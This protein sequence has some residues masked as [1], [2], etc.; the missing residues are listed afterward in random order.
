MRID[1]QS[2]LAGYAA[3]RIRNL[4]LRHATNLTVSSVSKFMDITQAE[5]YTLLEALVQKGL[6]EVKSTEPNPSWCCT[7]SGVQLA[8][9]SAARPIK[10]AT[11]ERLVNGLLDRANVI[12][13]DDGLPYIIE[14][15][16]VFGSF[17]TDK[18]KIGDVDIAVQLKRRFDDDALFKKMVDQRIEQAYERG[19]S[20]RTKFELAGF[21]QLEIYRKLKGPVNWISLHSYREMEEMGCDFLVLLD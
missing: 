7:D 6:I 4:L 20:P 11:A 1:P 13:A 12:N 8:F 5:A 18:E 14:R 21:A 3:I 2:E 16:A 15:M 17:L 10:R 19:W 9:T